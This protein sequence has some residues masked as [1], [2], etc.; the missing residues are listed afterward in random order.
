M[1][2]NSLAELKCIIA[3][4]PEGK[5]EIA[6]MANSCCN[7]AMHH[8]T[9]A[10]RAEYSLRETVSK[11]NPVTQLQPLGITPALPSADFAVRRLAYRALKRGYNRIRRT[12]P[13][14]NR[15]LY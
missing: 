9:T 14:A 5:A 3:S 1:G 2:F 15:R 13:T 7:Y 11:D 8:H 4:I 6:A 12:I 10:M